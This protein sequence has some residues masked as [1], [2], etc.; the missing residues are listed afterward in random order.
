MNDSM[1]HEHD[2]YPLYLIFSANHRFLKSKYFPAFKVGIGYWKQII[3]THHKNLAV[4]K[5]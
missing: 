5:I 3:Y 2:K 4:V 1:L